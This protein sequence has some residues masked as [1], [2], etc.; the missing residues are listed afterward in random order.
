M[1]VP[2]AQSL[3][4]EEEKKDCPKITKPE[5]SSAPTDW[6]EFKIEGPEESSSN[7]VSETIEPDALIL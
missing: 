2:E 1:K 7:M 3:R 4:K 5:K 6:S